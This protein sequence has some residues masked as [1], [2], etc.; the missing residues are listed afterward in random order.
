MKPCRRARRGHRAA[1]ASPRCSSSRCPRCDCDSGCRTAPPSRTTRRSTRRTRSSRSSSAPAATGRCSSPPPS[2][3]AWTTSRSCRPRSRSREQIVEQ[4]TTSSPSPRSGS[5]DDGRLIAFQVMPAEGP[6]ASPPRSSCTRCATCRPSTAT[7]TLGVAGSASGNI[8]ISER[9][10]EALPVYLLVVV[11]LSVL[12]LIVVFRSLLRPGPRDRSG[13]CCRFAAL[14]AIVAVFQWG[15]LGGVFG[16]D[17][18]GPILSFLPLDHHRRAVRAGDGLPAVPRL[19]HAGGLRPRHPG[20]GRRHRGLP[21]RPPVV[22]AAAIIMIAVFGGFIFSRPDDDAAARLRAR[23]RRAVRR[24]RGQAAAG[25]RAHAPVRRDG[26]VAAALADRILP[27]VDVEG[28][29]LERA[30]RTSTRSRRESHGRRRPE[31]TA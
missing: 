29:A 2:R 4:S 11:G 28:A 14:G 5:S 12:I 30:T 7:S 26:V 24:L 17:V 8:D 22:T 3:R 25:Q 20:A 16:V 27:N 23:L 15:W 31:P 9:L 13:S 6:T 1:S 19:R 18:P 10:A 21:G